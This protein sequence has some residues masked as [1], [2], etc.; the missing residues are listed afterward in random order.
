MGFHFLLHHSFISVQFSCSVVYDSLQPHELQHASPPCPSPTPGVH[1]DSHPLNQWCHSLPQV[2][3]M[4]GTQLHPSTENWIKDLLSMALPTR[5]RPS[6]LHSLPLP[7]GSFHEPLILIHQRGERMKT[8]I[9]ENQQ[10]WSL[11]SQPC[12]LQWNNEPRHVGLPKT[13]QVM[14]ESY[15][16]TW[17]TGEGNANHFSILALR[18]PWTVWKGKKIGHWKMNSPGW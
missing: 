7:S 11:G 1:S 9:T 8:T 15:D 12:L 17:S 16:K 5:A 6:F 14:V 2:N 10:N 13:R 18:I 3:N 4:E